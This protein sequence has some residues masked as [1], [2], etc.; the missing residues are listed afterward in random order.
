[1]Y[2]AKQEPRPAIWLTFICLMGV[3]YGYEVV[4]AGIPD[5]PSAGIHFVFDFTGL[6]AGVSDLQLYAADGY[7]LLDTIEIFVG[8]GPIPDENPPSPDPMTWASP[9]QAVGSNKITMTATTA[10]DPCS[11]PV[12]YYFGCQTVGGH[13]SIWQQDTTYVDS[14]LLPGTEYTYHVKAQDQMYNETFWSVPASATTGTIIYVDVSATGIDDGSSWV[15]AYNY[16]QDALAYASSDPN[17]YRICVA[18]GTYKPDEFDDP[19][20]V[21][22]D[23]TDTFQ[24]INGVAIYGGFPSGGGSWS[25]R[26]PNQYET[27]LSGDLDANDVGDLDDPT[28]C[29]NSY[30]VVTGSD[31]DATAVL[32]GFTITA[33]NA[34]GSGDPE[35]GGGMINLEGSP[36]VTNCTFRENSASDSGGAIRTYNSNMT[37]TNCSFIGNSAPMGGGMFTHLGSPTLVNC[38]FNGNTASDTGGA[39]SN[40]DNNPMLTN[41]TFSANFAENSGGGMFNYRASPTLTDC[42][43]RGNEATN[44]G[45]GMNNYALSFS[46]INC[47]FTENSGAN[48]GGMCNRVSAGP[49]PGDCSPT[50]VN[51]SFIGNETDSGGYGGGMCNLMRATPTVINC[52][53]SGNLADPGGSGMGGAIFNVGIDLTATNCSFS[54]NSAF[55]T[56]GLYNG[57]ITTLD[58]CI[59]WG[60][61]E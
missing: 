35:F 38:T 19:N 36:N 41:C 28:R 12:E 8:A 48:G 43:F 51:C 7:T 31:T 61:T 20:Y 54:N 32:D 46:S 40:V 1:M 4:A 9:P 33:G 11:P 60:N 16:L 34:D 29:E 21:P 59:F 27:I 55:G 23:R 6:E 53:F 2:I 26:D 47:T 24:L 52:I 57:G 45:G 10:N 3:F 50:L 15:D 5:P 25:G 14:G 22:G 44:D 13:D 30:H 37:V 17:V 58:N 42:V 56:G 39:M 18:E 49:G